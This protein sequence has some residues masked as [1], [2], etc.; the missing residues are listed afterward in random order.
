M[1]H[2]RPLLSEIAVRLGRFLK[3]QLTISA[4]LTVFHLVGFYLVAAPLWWLSGVLVGAL[5]IIPYLGFIVGAA[6]AVII[7]ALAGGSLPTLLWVLGVMLLAQIFE[8]V[9]LSPKILGTELDLHPALVFVLVVFG[10]IFF[11]PIGAFLAAP[12]AAVAL[13]IWRRR[14]AA[15]TTP[16][17]P[18]GTQAAGPA[19]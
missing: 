12:I 19:Q 8:G 10:A 6:L 1:D 11:G 14:S 5:T 9:Y 4:V 18:G 16:P 13:I 3:A 2:N 15:K 17:R 7:T